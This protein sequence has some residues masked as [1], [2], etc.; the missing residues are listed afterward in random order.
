MVAPPPGPIRNKA[1]HAPATRF[2]AAGSQGRVRHPAG[3]DDATRLPANLKLSLYV[4]YSPR[5]LALS[6]KLEGLEPMAVLRVVTGWA[7]ARV[8]DFYAF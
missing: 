3:S 7:N 1:D 6:K 5:R 4:A 2:D 8:G